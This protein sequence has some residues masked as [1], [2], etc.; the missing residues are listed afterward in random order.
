MRSERPQLARESLTMTTKI[1]RLASGL[2]HRREREEEER[3]KHGRMEQ[4]KIKKKN[5][6]NLQNR[7]WSMRKVMIFFFF[8]GLQQHMTHGYLN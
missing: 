6:V 7:T 2:G 4:E 3:K 1:L 8:S 5:L